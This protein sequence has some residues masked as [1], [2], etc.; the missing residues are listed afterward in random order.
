MSKKDIK[1]ATV[2]Y[3]PK[4]DNSIFSRNFFR[5]MFIGKT[6]SGKTYTF[7]QIFKSTL[8]KQ[9]DVVYVFTP[10]V[11]RIYYE[12]LMGNMGVV[13]TNTTVKG[14]S[15]VLKNI[16]DEQYKHQVY[17]EEYKIVCNDA[18]DPIYDR[19]ILI[20]FDDIINEKLKKDATYRE[21]YGFTRKMYMSV[22]F[23][24]QSTF[25]FTD[26][27]AYNNL[28][29][30]KKDID[31]GNLPRVKQLLLCDAQT[32]GGLLFTIAEKYVDE[33]LTDLHNAGLASSAIVGK[34]V[35]NSEGKIKVL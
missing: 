25:S 8:S 32:S 6:G 12:N 24:I 10:E 20:V 16:K 5:A 31:F 27:Y 17:D 1:E 3:L 34:I 29:F 7:N 15:S 14:I 13:Y 22:V 11:G 23:I 35:E 28:D 2:D 9:Y 4:W 30:V 19:Q 26:A 18:G 33:I 21:F